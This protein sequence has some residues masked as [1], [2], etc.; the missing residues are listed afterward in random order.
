MTNRGV[1]FVLSAPTGGGKTTVAREAIKKLAPKYPI[2]KV[3]T[4]TTR[5]PRNHE[6]NG[7][8]YH[9]VTEED[10]LCKQDQGFF[11][12][13][14]FYDGFLYGSPRSILHELDQG[15]S[16]LMVTDRPGAKIIK[17]ELPGA[18]LIWL[19]VPDISTVADRLHQRGTEDDETLE[20]RIELASREIAEEDKA[21]L[22]DHHIMNQN[23]DEAV[24]KL[25]SL[26]TTSVVQ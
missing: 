7:V 15:R 17:Q 22:F 21:P 1:L 18:V 19:G 10:F 8:D 11:I 20:R 16:F 9:F 4:Y 25:V 23:L 3:T 24:N 12:E 13:T 6:L 26:I 2:D 14:T 5:P